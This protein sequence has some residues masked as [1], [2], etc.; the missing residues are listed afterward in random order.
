VAGFEAFDIVE[1]IA[2]HGRFEAGTA[3]SV[4]EPSRDG[5]VLVELLDRGGYTIDVATLPVDKLRL[6]NRQS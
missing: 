4:L 1:L 5:G 3:G 2:G 6:V